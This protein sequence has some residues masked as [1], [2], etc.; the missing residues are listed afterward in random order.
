MQNIL[1]QIFFKIFKAI[2]EEN[3]IP[4]PTFIWCTPSPYPSNENFICALWA[5]TT[6]TKV[7]TECSACLPTAVSLCKA[8][9]DFPSLAAGLS[10][11][12]ILQKQWVRSTLSWILFLQRFIIIPGNW[13]W[14]QTPDILWEHCT[15]GVLRS[16][17]GE[18]KLHSLSFI[19]LV[20]KEE[21]LCGYQSVSRALEVCQGWKHLATEIHKYN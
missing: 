19:H 3:C 17:C 9:E 1:V 2:Y 4:E 8:N 21:C 16:S 7:K 18:I 6:C 15:D 13:V 11:L 14:S 20:D 10:Y 5:K 12:L